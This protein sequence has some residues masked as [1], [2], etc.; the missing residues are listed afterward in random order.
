MRAVTTKVTQA[1]F[2][3]GARSF[4][5]FPCDRGS[6][7]AFA[8]RSNAGK[9]SALNTAAGQRSLARTSKTPGRTREINFFELAESRRLVDLPGYGYARVSEV[10]RRRWAHMVERYLEG[11][12]SLQGVVL[13]MDVRHPFTDFDQRFI[14]WCRRLHLP[15]HILLTKADKLSNSR[16]QAALLAARKHPAMQ[17]DRFTIQL[18]SAQKRLGVQELHA[19]LDDWLQLG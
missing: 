2:L 13:V 8:G 6:E 4:A 7:V 12:Q 11:R 1:R 3:T 14:E 5:Q 18:F 9:S 10:E 19:R 15:G 16:A 17:H